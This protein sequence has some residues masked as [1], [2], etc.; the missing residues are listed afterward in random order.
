MTRT[1]WDG[2]SGGGLKKKCPP[3]EVGMDIFWNYTILSRY[4]PGGGS[5]CTSSPWSPDSGMKRSHCHSILESLLKG[6]LGGGDI[7]TII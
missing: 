5:L 1:P 4:F 7:A 2:N 6:L 3:W